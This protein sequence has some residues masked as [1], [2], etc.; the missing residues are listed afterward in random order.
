MRK[1]QWF[2][3]AVL[4]YEIQ[5]KNSKKKTIAVQRNSSKHLF[6]GYATSFNITITSTIILFIISISN[7]FIQPTIPRQFNTKPKAD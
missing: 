5:Q 2:P 6:N 4:T 1:T 3:N 7:V